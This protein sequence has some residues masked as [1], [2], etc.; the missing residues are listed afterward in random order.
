MQCLSKARPGH[1]EG[2]TSPLREF[3]RF[4]QILHKLLRASG[5]LILRQLSKLTLWQ[6]EYIECMLHRSRPLLTTKQMSASAKTA[7]LTPSVSLVQSRKEL[8]SQDGSALKYQNSHRLA[9]RSTTLLT[10]SCA[11]SRRRAA[12]SPRR[13]QRPTSSL[14]AYRGTW[15]MVTPSTCTRQFSGPLRLEATC[16]SNSSLWSDILCRKQQPTSKSSGESIAWVSSNERPGHNRA[17]RPLQHAG[18]VKS[19]WRSAGRP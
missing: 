8:T 3:G 15:Q 7:K 9:S 11:T 17:L 6:L 18:R 14:P 13:L 1:T 4:S 12:V 2:C 10:V 16:L 19:C 5:N